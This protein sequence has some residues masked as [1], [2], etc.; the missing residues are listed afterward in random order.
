MVKVFVI[1]MQH[2]VIYMSVWGVYC[3][4]LAAGA[5][6]YSIVVSQCHCYYCM[7][8]QCENKI[9]KVPTSKLP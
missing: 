4:F 5:V 1:E 8:D 2:F 9:C 3:L 6:L 7:I